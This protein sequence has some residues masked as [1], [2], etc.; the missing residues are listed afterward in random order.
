MCGIYT[1]LCPV[2]VHVEARGGCHALPYLL[3]KCLSLNLE[4]T[5]LA[6]LAD[7]RAPGICLYPCSPHNAGVCACIAILGFHIGARHWNSSLPDFIHSKHFYPPS[8][9]LSPRI[10]VFSVNG[11]II[12]SNSAWDSHDVCLLFYYPCVCMSV[13][14]QIHLSVC[15]CRGQKLSFTVPSLRHHPPP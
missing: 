9:L 5:V 8:H 14:V 11:R 2:L 13:R 7:Q 1:H 4:L 15:A 3:T 10:A 6:R 12:M